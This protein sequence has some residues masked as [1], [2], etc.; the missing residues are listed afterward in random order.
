MGSSID[1]INKFSTPRAIMLWTL[2]ISPCLPT[3]MTSFNLGGH[4]VAVDVYEISPIDIIIQYPERLGKFKRS[5]HRV[6]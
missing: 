6:P 3:G 4:E 2:K 5:Y 1:V